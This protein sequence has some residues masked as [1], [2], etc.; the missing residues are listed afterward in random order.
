MKSRRR[1]GEVVDE[2]WDIIYIYC[3]WIRRGF[4]MS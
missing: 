1:S 2:G 4:D 3:F